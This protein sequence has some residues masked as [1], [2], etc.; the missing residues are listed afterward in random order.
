MNNHTHQVAAAAYIFRDGK[1]LMLK[2]A[3]HPQTFV[4]PGG[5]L[6]VEE[7]P[8]AGMR[9]EVREETGLEVE[10]IGV[11]HTWYGR[12]TS[13][14]H[15]LLAINYLASWT[16][17]EPRLSDEHSEYLWVDRHQIETR[18]IITTDELGNGYR[19]EDLL[20]AFDRFDLL[21]R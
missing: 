9:R 3:Q 13:E 5:K 10:L 17:G 15:P 18:K 7:D 4:P 14:E 12:I 19:R 2:R 11:A 20:D 16:A 8:V 21:A 1:M 6:E